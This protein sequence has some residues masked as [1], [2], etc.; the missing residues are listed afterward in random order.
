MIF[1]ELYCAYYNAVAA[2]ISLAIK[3]KCTEKDM[4]RLTHEYAFE[5]SAL[6]IIPSLK[7]GK[8]QLLRKD[9]STPLKHEPTMPLTLL[10]KR[11]LKAISLDPRMKLFDIKLPELEGIDPLFTPEDYRIYDQYSDGLLTADTIGLR[12][13][14]SLVLTILYRLCSQK[15][16]WLPAMKNWWISAVGQQIIF[17]KKM[18]MY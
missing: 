12:E 3:G 18:W 8:W 13:R 11:W 9:M 5:E 10:Q 16:C 14:T 2:I 1:S 4:Q 15:M 7:S 17:L 6:S